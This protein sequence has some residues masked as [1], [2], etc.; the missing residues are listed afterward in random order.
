M[1]DRIGSLHLNHR[2]RRGATLGAAL[3]PAIDRAVQSGLPDALSRRINAMMGDDPAVIVIRELNTSV[4]LGATAAMLDGQ[5]V[6]H[7]AR[8]A[9]DAVAELLAGEVS[10]HQ[11]MRFADQTEFVG[12]FIVELIEGTA[13][14]RWY[15]GAFDRHRH[16]DTA[17]ALRA[18]LDDCGAG[19]ARVLGWL[20]RRGHLDAV[21][22]L[23]SPRDARRFCGSTTETLVQNAD[24]M[25]ALIKAAR[26]LLGAIDPSLID[27]AWFDARV[28]Q[29]LATAPIPV[30]WTDARGPSV[31]VAELVRWIAGDASRIDASRDPT[32]AIALRALLTGPL[33]WL[34]ASWLES[35]LIDDGDARAPPAPR[36]DS[37]RRHL[38]T[39][40]QDRLLERIASAL[41]ERRV[42]LPAGRDLDANEIVVRLIAAAAVDAVDAD[43][44]PDRSIVTVIEHAVRAGMAMRGAP[45]GARRTAFDEAWRS[46][47]PK[48]QAPGIGQSGSASI[49][50][51]RNAG[52]AALQL[53]RQL[54]DVLAPLAAPGVPTNAAGIFLLARAID[55]VRLPALAQRFGIE[56]GLLFGALATEWVACEIEPEEALV[57]WTGHNDSG[58]LDAQALRSMNVALTELLIDRGAIHPEAAETGTA[59][60]LARTARLL[61]RGWARW[62][63]GV[64]DASESF[65]LDRCVRRA[66]SLRIEEDRV[67]VRLEPAPLDVVLK[68]AGYLAR[69]DCVRWLGDRA[70]EFEIGAGK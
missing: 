43:D 25:P 48:I 30:S 22:A 52:T 70:V 69:I 8:S 11:V 63:P 39:P 68:M 59:E 61:V 40:R 16:A 32:V 6:E 23:V 62:L 65:L 21:L 37:V 33:D 20:S 49:A 38:L 54:A 58:T 53:L 28:A 2:L 14:E 12:S 50:A 24:G 10:P 45:A 13:L 41:R 29:Y 9:A 47:D 27:P 57:F 5:V 67:L 19:A 51:L 4:Q 3:V 1:Q 64:S 55:D 46:N 35:E 15:F 18:V 60:P 42:R 26:R 34:D 44:P 66:G 17:A 7:V 56:T 36:L 31:R